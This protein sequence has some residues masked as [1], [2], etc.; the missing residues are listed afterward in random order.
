MNNLKENMEIKVLT[1][2]KDLKNAL[3][4]VE[5]LISDLNKLKVPEGTKSED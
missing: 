3:Q 4:K 5:Y 2:R 1:L